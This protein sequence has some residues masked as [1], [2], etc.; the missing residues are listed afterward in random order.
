MS[1]IRKRQA[2]E[3]KRKLE[4][5]A[6]KIL[7]EKST[8]IVSKE[9]IS[10]LGS[11][12][13][14][15][16]KYNDQFRYE[17][18][19]SNGEKARKN[20]YQR[21]ESRWSRM[22]VPKMEADSQSQDEIIVIEDDDDIVIKEEPEDV[23]SGYQ[24][25]VPTPVLAVVRPEIVENILYND[26]SKKDLPEEIQ[27][28]E[29]LMCENMEDKLEKAQDEQITTKEQEHES[30][31]QTE[32]SY[33]PESTEEVV[34]PTVNVYQTF[35]SK[36]SVE[37]VLGQEFAEIQDGDDGQSYLGYIDQPFDM[38]DPED[39]YSLYF[40]NGSDYNNMIPS[41]HDC[42]LS[43][44]NSEIPYLRYE[45][46]LMNLLPEQDVMLSQHSAPS[47]MELL[48][49]AERN[50][51]DTIWDAFLTE[52]V[53]YQEKSPERE[54]TPPPP[55]TPAEEEE[56]PK[57]TF[58]ERRKGKSKT[59]S[60]AKEPSP[61]REEIEHVVEKKSNIKPAEGMFFFINFCVFLNLLES[62]CR[63]VIVNWILT[64]NVINVLKFLVKKYISCYKIF[65]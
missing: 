43:Q 30:V 41:L 34:A 13:D 44:S 58:L 8:K 24:E 63:T 62:S 11:T 56:G 23:D 39:P 14:S 54:A 20:R 15:V 32:E 28:E 61:P 26:N 4:I 38:F 29:V 57:V 35:L 49:G 36:P 48:E 59:R 51:L 37:D 12:Q 9:S 31:V 2:A 53:P 10:S 40:P 50:E 3:E 45:N 55:L 18:S 7:I 22:A 33:V 19:I 6:N 21:T 5:Q 65:Y 46:A 25:P 1:F 60:K 52:T 16:M 47:M 17:S 42:V 64:F 27:Q